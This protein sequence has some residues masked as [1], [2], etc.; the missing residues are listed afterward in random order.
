MGRPHIGKRA[1]T[2]AERQQR[3]RKKLDKESA[4]ELRKRK[5]QMLLDEKAQ[6]YQPR[7]PGITY[8]RRVTVLTP[9]G[10][11]EV[12]TSLTRPLATCETELE[13]EDILALL[14]R[15]LQIAE[16]RGLDLGDAAHL[17]QRAFPRL[18]LSGTT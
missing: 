2:D 13:D 6:R 17:K 11:Q 8:A 4:A 9:E 16:Q 1:M 12:W 10:D 18:G 3:H 5:R 14:C 7:P 15:L